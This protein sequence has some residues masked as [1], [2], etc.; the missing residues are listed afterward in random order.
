MYKEKYKHDLQQ[1]P[2]Q[3]GYFSII[4]LLESIPDV[5]WNTPLIEVV[6]YPLL[7]CASANEIESRSKAHGL[8]F[9]KH[10]KPEKDEMTDLTITRKFYVLRERL[11]TIYIKF[12]VLKKAEL[13][14]LFNM[15]YGK[16]LKRLR[17]R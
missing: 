9:D 5:P 15:K 11:L 6:G 10:K 17:K 4:D 12:R 16:N 8:Q 7:M 2:L 14:Y 13:C 3:L 1:I